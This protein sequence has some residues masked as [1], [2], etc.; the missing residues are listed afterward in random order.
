MLRAF[1]MMLQMKA[2]HLCLV[3]VLRFKEK[4][5]QFSFYPCSSILMKSLKIKIFYM[6]RI[7]FVWRL[8]CSANRTD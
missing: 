8:G 2:H 7:T 3:L 1:Q 4:T 5:K 6:H